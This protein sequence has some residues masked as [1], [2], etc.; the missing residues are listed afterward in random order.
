MWVTSKLW[1]TYHRPERVREAC[2]KTLKDMGLDYL[3]LYLIHYPL[4]MKFVPF[5][6]KYPAGFPLDD[7]NR[8][9]MDEGVSIEDTWR[10]ME[11]LVD[12]G[13]V[14]NIGFSNTNIQLLRDVCSYAKIKPAVVQN[15][16]HPYNSCQKFLRFC[17][18]KGIAV[19]AYSSLGGASYTGMGWAQEAESCLVD[20]LMA[21][22]GEAHGKTAAQVALRWAVQRGTAVLPKTTN[23][24]R[25]AENIGLFDFALTDEEMARLDG[26]NRDR[27]F[28]DPGD[29]LESRFGNLEPV[30]D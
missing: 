29:N 8:I 18:E 11:G 15:E 27:R 17:R 9:M 22:I 21:E 6:E 26:A 4:A 25:L 5:E 24:G 7:K 16:I 28:C 1:N 23:P 19:T 2:V 13:L 30:W 10:A 20:P 3:D 14:R 12:E